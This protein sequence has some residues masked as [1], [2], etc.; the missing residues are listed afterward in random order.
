MGND[1]TDSL[2]EEG[3]RRVPGPRRVTG[4][5]GGA[6]LTSLKWLT[7]IKTHKL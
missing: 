7:Q 3:G 6:A 1:V 2:E 4:G 5:G